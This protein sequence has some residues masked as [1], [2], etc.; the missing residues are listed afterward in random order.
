MTGAQR[1]LCH[2]QRVLGP[3]LEGNRRAVRE[4]ELDGA[5]GRAGEAG[6]LGALPPRRCVGPTSPEGVSSRCSGLGCWGREVTDHGSKATGCGAPYIPGGRTGHWPVAG[7]GAQAPAPARHGAEGGGSGAGYETPSSVPRS[8]SI[9]AASIFAKSVVEA[10]LGA[11]GSLC[12]P[13]ISC[14]LSSHCGSTRCGYASSRAPSSLSSRESSC[15]MNGGLPPPSSA[16]PNPST[17]TSLVC[18]G[19]R[20]AAV[21]TGGGGTVSPAWCGPE[22]K[23]TAP[24]TG[25]RPAGCRHNAVVSSSPGVTMVS[26][27]TG[28]AAVL[29]VVGGRAS[30]ARDR[31]P[32][33]WLRRGKAR[34]DRTQGAGRGHLSCGRASRRPIRGTRDFLPR[35]WGVA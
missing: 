34:G 23:G 32:R 5:P 33:R 8:R 18:M 19:S 3:E 13:G 14:T 6:R 24:G 30:S 35:R 20:P 17:G 11:A 10:A 31:P 27:A 21:A 12:R 15:S 16:A 29:T 4:R 26:I 2:A 28:C 22:S 25:H 9:S 7:G 1:D